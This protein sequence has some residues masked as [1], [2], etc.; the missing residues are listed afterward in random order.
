MIDIETLGSKPGSVIVAIAAVRFDLDT[1]NVK[2]SYVS[3]VDP[4]SCVKKGLK[5]EVDTL[6]WWAEK[7]NFLDIISGTTPIYEALRGLR[8]YL[9]EDDII[10]ANAPTFDLKIIE[11]AYKAHCHAVPWNYYNERCVRTLS[12]LNPEIRKNTEFIGDRH[13]PLDDCYHQI[14]Y[15]CSTWKSLT[16]KQ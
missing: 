6:K 11:A 12:S 4:D 14:K 1:G 8:N 2:K 10:W 5:I 15:C 13:D 7:D 3:H 9:E 16:N